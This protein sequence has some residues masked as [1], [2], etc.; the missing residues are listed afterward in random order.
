MSQIRVVQDWRAEISCKIDEVGGSFSVFVFLGNVP[1]DPSKWLIDPGFVGTFDIFAPN[2]SP[3]DP[4]NDSIVTGFVH[5]NRAI[6][7]LSRQHSLEDSAVLPF[8][9]Q[10]I[11]WGIQKVRHRFLHSA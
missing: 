5:L 11:N 4:A 6:L 7:R 1:A 8:L 10:N 2:S 3:Y 9:R